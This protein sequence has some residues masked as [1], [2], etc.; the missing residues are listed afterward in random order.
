MTGASLKQLCQNSPVILHE[1][2]TVGF[3]SVN[4]LEDDR[5]FPW[6]C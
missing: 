6:I 5:T 1:N 3:C 2:T 4:L